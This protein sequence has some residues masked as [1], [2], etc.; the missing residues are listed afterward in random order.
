M[1]VQDRHIVSGEINAA[2]TGSINTNTSISG[3]TINV[4][5]S[6]S[7]NFV[8]TSISGN[9]V[10]V[11]T[12]ISGNVITLNS[13]ETSVNSKIQVGQIVLSPGLNQL[14]DVPLN[15]WVGFRLRSGDASSVIFGGVSG[16]APYY[17]SEVDYNGIKLVHWDQFQVTNLNQFNI[18]STAG[19]NITLSYL[20]YATSG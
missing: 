8:N 6:V 11:N 3:Q 15:S 7:G 2:V 1:S 4:N 12:S 14:P 5:T 18:Y 20:G 16:N 13:T 19:S 17:N 10:N 9:V